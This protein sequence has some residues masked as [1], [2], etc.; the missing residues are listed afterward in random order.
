MSRYYRSIL[1]VQA[2]VPAFVPTDIAG[3]QIWLDAADA[4]TISI[5]TGVSQWDN[6]GVLGGNF[7]QGTGGA[8]PAYITAGLNGKNILRF[9]GTKQLIGSLSAAS[10]NYWHQDVRTDF[11]VIK[12]GTISDPNALYAIFGNAVLTAQHGS[13]L[14]YDDRSSVPRNNFLIHN[15]SNNNASVY[16]TTNNAGNSFTANAW[17]KFYVLADPKNA[18]AANRSEIVVGITSYKNNTST[19]AAST[20]NASNAIRVG[21]YPDLSGFLLVGDL[22][23]IISYNKLLSAGEITQ[24]NNYIFNK[25]AI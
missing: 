2:V 20:T 10:Y 9:D 23:E 12:I 15:T 16:N 24:V 4:S 18:T 5:G 8:Q 22:A 6:K 25:W 13:S 1:N 21:G 19:L 7:N 14:S 17:G 11:Y 3:C